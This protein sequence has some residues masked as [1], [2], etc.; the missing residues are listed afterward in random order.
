MT[1]VIRLYVTFLG[2][3]DLVTRSHK[4]TFLLYATP[5]NRW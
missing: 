4:T 5:A 2:L 3:T 1:A